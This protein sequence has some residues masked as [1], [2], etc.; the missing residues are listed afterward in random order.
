MPGIR[1][2]ILSLLASAALFAQVPDYLPLQAGNTWVYRSKAGSFTV[3]TGQP[4][5]FGGNEYFSV[6]GFPSA[7]ELWLRNTPEGRIMKWDSVVGQ[8]RIWLDTSTPAGAYSPTSVDRCT[9]ASRIESR[10]AKYEGPVGEF[11]TVLAVSYIAGPCGDAGLIADYFLPWVG[12]LRRVEQSIA[13]PRSYDL[14]YARLGGV[15]V[16]SAPESGFGLSLTQTHGSLDARL[17][18]RHTGPEPLTLN[19]STSQQFDL[20]VFD[21]SGKVVYQWSE[22]RGF[23]QVLTTLTVSGEKLWFVEIPPDRLPPGRYAIRAWL[24]TSDGPVYTASTA[25]TVQKN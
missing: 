22:G 9:A 6:R 8:E 25:V 2:S 7:P 19:F 3:E 23:L 13:G 18:L 16:I 21:E 24:T 15:T 10:E 20:Q 14:I 12:L 5:T 17:A 4:S 11:T 1:T